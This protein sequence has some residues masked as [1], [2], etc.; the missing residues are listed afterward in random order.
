MAERCPSTFV[1]VKRMAE[2]QAEARPANADRTTWV[3]EV[4]LLPVKAGCP[5]SRRRRA[6]VSP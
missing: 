6:C 3:T 1:A 2:A 5:L 4:R